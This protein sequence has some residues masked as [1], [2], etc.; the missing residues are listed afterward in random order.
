M[1][2]MQGFGLRQQVV[3]VRYLQMQSPALHLDER[4]IPRQGIHLLAYHYL[5]AW[6]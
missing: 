3:S 5:Q 1:L 2:E 6:S 4:L